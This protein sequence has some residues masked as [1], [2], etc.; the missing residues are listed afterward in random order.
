[1]AKPYV[2]GPCAIYCGIGALYAPIF[3]GHSERGVRI[4]IA[5]EYEPVHNDLGGRVPIDWLYE[6]ETAIISADLTRFNEAVY[7]LIAARPRTST[8]GSVPGVNVPGDIGTMMITEG[9]AYPLWLVF[10]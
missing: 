4:R 5:P 3:L 7:E 6:G 1:M 8:L 2:T 9:F 10:P